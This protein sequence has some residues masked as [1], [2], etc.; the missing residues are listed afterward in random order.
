MTKRTRERLSA[1]AWFAWLA[2]GV[3]VVFLTWLHAP[4]VDAR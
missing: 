1:A 4:E 2:L 3:A